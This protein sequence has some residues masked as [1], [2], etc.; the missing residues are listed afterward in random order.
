MTDGSFMLTTRWRK[1]EPMLSLATPSGDQAST[2]SPS[3]AA[4]WAPGPTRPATVYAGNGAMS[5]YQER[6]R[7]RED[8][9]VDH[10]D[11][12]HAGGA[13]AAAATSGARALIVVN[14]GVG[15]LTE[16][17]GSA[18]SRSRACTATPAPT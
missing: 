13:S 5:D 6:R 15:G 1:G 17:V 7:A 11:C 12:G 10:S 3:G 2:P 14:D 4:R 9:V 8:R 16:Y 18:R